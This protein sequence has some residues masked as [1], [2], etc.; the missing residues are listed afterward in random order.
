MVGYERIGK[1][2]PRSPHRGALTADQLARR[3]VRAVLVGLGC[4][5]VMPMPFLAPGDL[6]R[7]GVRTDAVRLSNPLVA[8]ESVLR[9]ALLPGL[10]ATLAYNATHRAAGLSV[11]ELGHCYARPAGPGEM[12]VE[13]AELGVALAGREA[14]A[15]VHVAAAVTEVLG[16]DR[17]RVVP[18]EAPGL[19]PTRAGTVWVG[20]VAVG[21]VGEVDP[22]IA[23]AAGVAERVAW[24]RLDLDVLLALPRSLRQH[25]PVSRYPTADI[26]LAFVVDESIPVHEV[27]DLLRRASDLVAEVRLFDVYRGPQVG[28]RAR[29][30]AFGLRLQAA[31][32]TLTDAEVAEVRA[33]LIEAVTSGLDAGLRA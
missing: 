15:A 23:A 7:V 12:P 16:L 21:E 26:D 3:E 31:D 33:A 8:E 29:S 32:R 25:R 6:E 2:V 14:P 4:D 1:T 9:T 28:D 22:D 5:E 10:L 17:P 27:T 18:A 20:E 11:F 24:L 30:L 19:H 13:W